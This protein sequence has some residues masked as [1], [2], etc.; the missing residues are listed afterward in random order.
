MLFK[1]EFKDVFK[2]EHAFNP[3]S[4]PLVFK[5]R[6]IALTYYVIIYVFR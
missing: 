1:Y 5:L 3:K 2:N 6:F 4:F